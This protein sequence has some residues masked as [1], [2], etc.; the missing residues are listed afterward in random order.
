MEIL[1]IFTGIGFL[2]E[3]TGTGIQNLNKIASTGFKKLRIFVD[4]TVLRLGAGYVNQHKG[5]IFNN[6]FIIPATAAS[7]HLPDHE[8]LCTLF[9]CLDAIEEDFGRFKC[10]NGWFRTPAT[11]GKYL[12]TLG[13][14][15]RRCITDN[16]CCHE[17]LLIVNT[18]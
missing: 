15:Q 6:V 16:N 5:Q 4:T 2:K 13:N 1:K 3:F 9:G 10:I 18:K 7:S 11:I 17:G 14:T 8:S 12:W